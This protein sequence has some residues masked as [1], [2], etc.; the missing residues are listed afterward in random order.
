MLAP[1]LLCALAAA[2]APQPAVRATRV[3]QDSAR[4]AVISV[5]PQSARVRVVW[6]DEAGQ[7]LRTF[8]G[9][10]AFLRRHGEEVVALTN[11]GIFE[12][13]HAPT[14]LLVSGGV[15]LAPLN[16]RG[17]KGNFYLAPN[18]VF[19]VDA[20]GRARVASTAR[21]AAER[22]AAVEATQSGPLLLEGGQVNGAFDPRSSQRKLRS[23]VGVRPDG[24]V[25]LVLSES[26]VT[27]HQLAALFRDVLGCEDALYLDGVISALYAPALGRR[28]VDTGQFAG[29][30]GV[31][32]IPRD[33]R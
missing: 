13:G 27:F 29:M 33:A 5:P 10:R 23:G 20:A 19:Y 25:V 18:G 7:P 8:E 9:A 26:E 14:G 12:P 32:Q 28:D 3:R 21:F 30:L 11:A 15:T 17:G 22:P 2:G 31:V 6:K 1:L 24:G 16:T 4:Y